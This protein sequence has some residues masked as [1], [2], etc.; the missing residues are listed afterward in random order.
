MNELIQYI[1]NNKNQRVGVVVATPTT[2]NMCGWGAGWAMCH[3]GKDK[4]DEKVGLSI[5]RT[6]A[7]HGL[8]NKIVPPKI[9]M[10]VY[11]KICERG[12]KYF[13]VEEPARTTDAG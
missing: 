4:F 1:R 10:P 8:P 11:T 2:R 6:R 12:A 3:K 9:V 5:A 7:I 13:K